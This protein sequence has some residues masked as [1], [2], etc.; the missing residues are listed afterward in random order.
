[1]FATGQPFINTGSIPRAPHGLLQGVYQALP[2][3]VL[4]VDQGDLVELQRIR[5]NPPA[6]TACCRRGRSHGTDCRSRDQSRSD[7]WKTGS[8]EDAGVI[9]D[10]ASGNCSREEM[11][12]YRLHLVLLTKRFATERLASARRRRHP[13]PVRF[14]RLPCRRCIDVCNVGG[15]AGPYLFTKGR[16][17]AGIGAGHTDLDRVGSQSV[18]KQRARRRRWS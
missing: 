18:G 14:A 6:T 10:F 1:M 7:W 16:V 15:D 11:P 4:V 13:S 8:F 5:K 12:D 3:G 17:G 9:I 2:I